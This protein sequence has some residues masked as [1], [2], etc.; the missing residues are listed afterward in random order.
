MSHHRPSY[1]FN[2]RRSSLVNPTPIEDEP[3]EQRT[4]R[5]KS[6]SHQTLTIALE[7]LIEH[8][9][10]YGPD[11]VPPRDIFAS[12]LEE[13]KE[14]FIEA[15]IAARNRG[16]KLNIKTTRTTQRATGITQALRSRE[17]GI[18]KGTRNP[19]SRAGA[20][21]YP[22]DREERAQ[23]DVVKKAIIFHQDHL[24][25]YLQEDTES[26]NSPAE[27]GQEQ[28][29]EA[30]PAPI[31]DKLNPEHPKPPRKTSKSNPSTYPFKNTDPDIEAEIPPIS[32]SNNSTPQTPN[33]SQRKPSPLAPQHRFHINH[34][35]HLA[36]TY[37]VAEL[38]RLRD[39]PRYK[40][41]KRFRYDFS[42]AR[43]ITNTD[44]VGKKVVQRNPQER[45][46]Q[47]RSRSRSR[48]RNRGN[49]V[50][51]GSKKDRDRD[52]LRAHIRDAGLVSGEAWV[53]GFEG[54]GVVGVRLVGRPFGRDGGA[55][56]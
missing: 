38:A 33:P 49:G 34:V 16:R 47:R 29:E 46:Q 55:V 11:A 52:V 1:L 31:T 30:T 50:S 28:D 5:R 13:N 3:T 23:L 21:L 6:S 10:R 2:E 39:D 44:H 41:G 40:R 9:D 25:E 8:R 20:V 17:S 43:H 18:R 51:K 14:W 24:D 53:D 56:R 22:S 54:D 42:A 7:Q 45:Q 32:S 37:I 12:W 19:P 4:V 27:Q 48:S 26:H 36:P 35:A 15:R